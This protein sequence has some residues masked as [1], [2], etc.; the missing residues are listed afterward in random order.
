MLFHLDG[1]ECDQRHVILFK[2]MTLI[3]TCDLTFVDQPIEYPLNVES[4][5]G[6][7]DKIDFCQTVHQVTHFNL[8][9]TMTMLTLTMLVSKHM[10]AIHSCTVC[11]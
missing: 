5:K 1:C 6:I 2:T 4:H 3:I 9:Q 7:M 10:L 8:C 11:C